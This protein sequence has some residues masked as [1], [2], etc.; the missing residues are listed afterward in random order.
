MTKSQPY[1]SRATM[2]RGP[3][4]SSLA[5]FV[6]DQVQALE[7]IKKRASWKRKTKDKSFESLIASLR[8]SNAS[9]PSGTKRDVAQ[10]IEEDA[11]QV[12][13]KAKNMVVLDEC[14]NRNGVVVAGA[15][16]HPMQ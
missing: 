13:K 12:T 11:I 3:Q 5:N 10:T 2:T 4:A 16:P 1:T 6:S 15:Q 8:E 14:A 9:C 7:K